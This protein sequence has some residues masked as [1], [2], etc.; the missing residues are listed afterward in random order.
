MKKMYTL[1][2]AL[3]TSFAFSQQNISFEASE[4]YQLG[5]LHAQNG[6]E[7]TEGIDGILANQTISNEQAS[8]G[9]FSFKNAFEPTFNSQW[10]PIFGAA[11]TFATPLDFTDLTVSYDV[12]VTGKNGSDF[13]FV[14]YSINAAEEFV[15]VAGVGIENRGY[16]Y[17]TKD[18]DYDF[19]Y[20]TAQWTPNEWINIKI[21]I[22]AAQIKYYVNNV[23]Q[24]TIANFTQ[25]NVLGLNMLHN[26]YGNDAYYDNFVISTNAL[27]TTP[28]E[29][30]Q[31]V[32]YPNPATDVVSLTSADNSEIASIA[33][34]N[35]SGQA[36]L[37]TTQTQNI[38][39]STLAAGTYFLQ[40]K[41]I[42]GTSITRKMVKL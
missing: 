13:E 9:S 39:I 37:E 35:L 24:N 16:I 5:S 36:V 10:F 29:Q 41:S 40:A 19:D 27:S 38:N 32:M 15:P 21:E 25:L 12:K 3:T 22:S 31:L 4:G 28:F 18:A 2:V 8:S 34:Y 42:S 26:N 11:K 20:A 6:W 23:L 7:V 1:L 33:I 17:L 30:S 14:L